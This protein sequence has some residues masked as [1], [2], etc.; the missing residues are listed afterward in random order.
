[1]MHEGRVLIDVDSDTKKN[2]RVEDLL[3]MFETASGS[4]LVNDRML[5]G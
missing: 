2:L 3:K 5:L 1:M 4:G